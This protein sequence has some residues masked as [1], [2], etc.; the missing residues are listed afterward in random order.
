MLLSSLSPKPRGGSLVVTYVPRSRSILGE[1]PEVVLTT[2][3][4]DDDHV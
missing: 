2:S 1:K 4:V 3:E